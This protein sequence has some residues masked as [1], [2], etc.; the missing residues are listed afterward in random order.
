MAARK[1]ARA[2]KRGPKAKR[3][4]AMKR[5]GLTPAHTGGVYM[6]TE[7]G[8]RRLSYAPGERATAR[9]IRQAL[10]ITER[11]VKKAGRLI[12]RLERLGR[13]KKVG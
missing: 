9:D 4:G 7:S 11:Q 10:G 13:I 1:K 3:A 12:A 8:V 6:V 2:A 5:G